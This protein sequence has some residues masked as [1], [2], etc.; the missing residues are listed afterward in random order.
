MRMSVRIT[1]K[2]SGAMRSSASRPELD[3]D[4]AML[5]ARQDLGQRLADLRP[6]RR[7]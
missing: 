4:D 7:R 1:S 3:A 5:R 6:R 2:R